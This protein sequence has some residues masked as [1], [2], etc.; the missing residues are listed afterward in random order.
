[1]Q[2][3][4]P[5]GDGQAE[6]RAAAHR[7]PAGTA[8]EGPEALEDALAVGHRDAGTLVG[9][10]EHEVVALPGGRHR[11]G[12][13]GR[14][15][16]GGVVEHVGDELAQAGGVGVHDETGGPGPDVV[17]HLAAGPRLGDGRGEQGRD[18]DGLGGVGRAPGVD[19]GE[20]E[21]V[22]DEPSHA[23]GLRQRGR[24]VVGV[25]RGD[26]VDEVLEHRAEG[27]ER[28]PQLVAHGGHEVASLLV[29]GGEVERP[30][31]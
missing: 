20:V 23:L 10:L 15:V 26:A 7:S 3:A 11:D 16:P 21:Q 4:H 19:L 31:C 12:P 29:D 30:S 28:R 27:G 1:M 2:V 13:A 9:H 24:E 5:A 25:R 18:R 17:A 14:A 8:L 6:A 22:V